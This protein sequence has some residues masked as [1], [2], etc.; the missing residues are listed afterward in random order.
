MPALF[1]LIEHT[2]FVFQEEQIKLFRVYQSAGIQLSFLHLL[3]PLKTPK[4]KREEQNVQMM[5]AQPL[6]TSRHSVESFTQF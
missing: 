4:T 5:K 1:F 6:Y 3:L 2:A